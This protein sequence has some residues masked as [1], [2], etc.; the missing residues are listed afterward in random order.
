MNARESA[1]LDRH[2]T[3]NYGEDQFRDDE[4]N[5]AAYA[6]ARKAHERPERWVRVTSGWVDA[7]QS[8]TPAI[9]E[10]ADLQE[11]GGTQVRLRYP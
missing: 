5:D 10:A 1:A 8:T 6:E 4:A 11:W 2:I 9:L 7:N 3:G